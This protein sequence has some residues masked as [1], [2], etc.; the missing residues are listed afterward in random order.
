MDHVVS[1]LQVLYK[2]HSYGEANL[3]VLYVNQP[4]EEKKS[5][6]LQ[7]GIV[8]DASRD[9]YAPSSRGQSLPQ[10]AE[11]SS[12]PRLLRA[13]AESIDL[14]EVEQGALLGRG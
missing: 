12:L 1:K 9:S 11:V 4:L 13:R 5:P 6:L 2:V 10:E 8:S 7:D 14:D 3:L